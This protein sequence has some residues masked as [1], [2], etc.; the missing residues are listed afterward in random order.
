[1]ERARLDPATCRCDKSSSKYP[2]AGGAFSRGL[3][4]LRSFAGF[5]QFGRSVSKSK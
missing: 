1:M 5:S 2:R 4:F 3:G